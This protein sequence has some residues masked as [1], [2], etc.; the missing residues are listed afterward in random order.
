MWC[1]SCDLRLT[2]LIVVSLH[3]SQ[4]HRR[5]RLGHGSLSLGGV[6]F[7]PVVA[8]T[9]LLD[10]GELW[11]AAGHVQGVR[12]ACAQRDWFNDRQSQGPN[13]RSHIYHQQ[14]SNVDFYGTRKI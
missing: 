6:A 10:A 3:H 11:W 12:K 2:G 13:N 1:W 5:R 7:G 8:D 4:V 9:H 14:H